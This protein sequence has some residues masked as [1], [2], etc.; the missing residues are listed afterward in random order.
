MPLFSSICPSGVWM[1]GSK[2]SMASFDF[3]LATVLV[4]VW[5]I[6][7]IR[8]LMTTSV[9]GSVECPELE[10]MRHLQNILG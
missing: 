6:S 9:E 3:W 10:F 7:M 8:M 4:L 5:Q 2:R 1:M